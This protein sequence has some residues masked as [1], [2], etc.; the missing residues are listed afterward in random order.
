M[1][2]FD[3]I[4]LVFCTIFDIEFQVMFKFVCSPT[5]KIKHPTKPQ[6]SSPHKEYAKVR[7]TK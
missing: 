7:I 4:Y 6:Q 1:E 5:T 2:L 3:S